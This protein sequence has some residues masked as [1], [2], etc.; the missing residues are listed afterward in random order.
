MRECPLTGSQVVEIKSVHGKGERVVEGAGRQAPGGWEH[1]CLSLLKQTRG[2][3][4]PFE[5][6][7]PR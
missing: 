4:E 6:L 7:G 3:S 2:F 5:S 1:P